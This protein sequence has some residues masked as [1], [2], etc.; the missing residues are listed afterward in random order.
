M[1]IDWKSS[2]SG[3]MPETVSGLFLFQNMNGLWK[4]ANGR[5]PIH[6]HAKIK[7]L[8]GHWQFW[9]VIWKKKMG[10]RNLN[11]HLTAKWSPDLN[12]LWMGPSQ[13]LHQNYSITHIFSYKIVRTHPRN[14]PAVCWLGCVKSVKR[15]PNRGIKQRYQDV[16]VLNYVDFY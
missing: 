6:F 13:N 3:Y 16:K 7:I 8:M 15:T 1:R 4:W 12:S 10:P 14:I 2:L 5:C 11:I 9:W